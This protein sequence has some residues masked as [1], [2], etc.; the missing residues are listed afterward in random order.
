MRHQEN[1]ALPPMRSNR[2]GF[3]LIIN[4]KTTPASRSLNA[5]RCFSDRSATPPCRDAT[6][7]RRL[8][9]IYSE[10]IH[11]FP[12]C[13][14]LEDFAL[15]GSRSA[16]RSHPPF[17]G[18]ASNLL[19]ADRTSILLRQPFAYPHAAPAM[20]RCQWGSC[21]MGKVHLPSAHIPFRN[22]RNRQSCRATATRTPA[23]YTNTV[24]RHESNCG[25]YLMYRRKW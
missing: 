15:S 5:S 24:R 19:M 16:R 21:T 6:R 12:V 20:C 22:S 10:F 18:G 17:Q 7:G 8:L 9:R 14:L 3:P 4:R 23:H 13:A 2:G 25:H 1:V 11:T